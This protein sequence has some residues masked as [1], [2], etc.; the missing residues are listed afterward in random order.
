M[1]HHSEK[2]TLPLLISIVCDIPQNKYLF[3]VFKDFYL[4]RKGPMNCFSHTQNLTGF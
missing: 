3:L 4:K 2:A 1:V